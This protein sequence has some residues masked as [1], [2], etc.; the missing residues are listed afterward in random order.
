MNPELVDSHC[1]LDQLSDSSTAIQEAQTRAVSRL[2][3]VSESADSM[4][5]VLALKQNH[6]ATVL[7]ALG[8]HPAWITQHGKAEVEGGLE[9]LSLHLARVPGSG[10]HP[11]SSPAAHTLPATPKMPPGSPAASQAANL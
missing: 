8:M 10:G 6:R 7:A 2:V 11:G 3:A 1:H 4:P 5:A 9:Y